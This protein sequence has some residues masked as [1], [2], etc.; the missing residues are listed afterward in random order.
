MLE[1][2][3]DHPVIDSFIILS[4]AC[5]C[6]IGDEK[7]DSKSNPTL[8]CW[9]S[10]LFLLIFAAALFCS[11]CT[12]KPPGTEELPQG[13]SQEI[14]R[15]TTSGIVRDWLTDYKPFTAHPAIDYY[16]ADSSKILII[17]KTKEGKPMDTLVNQWRGKGLYS[18]GWHTDRGWVNGPYVYEFHAGDILQRRKP[19]SI[20]PM[21]WSSGE[22]RGCRLTAT[23]ASP[24]RISA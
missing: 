12:P 7:S 5:N 2:L 20:L 16:V 18:A 24:F 22:S 19:T 17:I 13:R 15:R 21:N 8:V 4:A 14:A 9:A 6:I 1:A 11:S 23:S 3:A 10:G